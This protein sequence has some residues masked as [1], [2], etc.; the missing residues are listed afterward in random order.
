MTEEGGVNMDYEEA[1]KSWF[2]L[3]RYL[4]GETLR[5]AA[6]FLRSLLVLLPLMYVLR[7]WL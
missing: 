4:A 2:S 1:C 7:F 3:A 5:S 6:D